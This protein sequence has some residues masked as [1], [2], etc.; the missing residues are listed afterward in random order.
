MFLA[1]VFVQ[2]WFMIVRK[3]NEKH[4]RGYFVEISNSAKELKKLKV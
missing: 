3:I 1:I 4:K 2:S